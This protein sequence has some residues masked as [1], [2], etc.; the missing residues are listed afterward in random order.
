MSLRDTAE[1]NA[2]GTYGSV[3]SETL[4]FTNIEKLIVNHE[5]CIVSKYCGL[6]YIG[7]KHTCSNEQTQYI[8]QRKLNIIKREC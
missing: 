6:V 4:L 5:E 7:V 2:G 1:Y 8:Q 3:N